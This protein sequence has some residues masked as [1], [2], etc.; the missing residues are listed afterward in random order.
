MHHIASDGWSLG[1]LTSEFASLYNAA[2]RGEPGDL[3][4]LPVQYADYASWQRRWLQ[5]E[6]LQGQL[7]YW[8]RQL[9]GV[10]TVHSLPLDRPRSAMQSFRG[11]TLKRALD[12]DLAVRITA[13]CRQQD[14]TLFMLL[15]TAFA[16][17]L[18]RYSDERDIVVGTPIAGRTH[19]DV[20]PLIG[21]FVNSLALRTRVEP[22]HA[23]I[24]QLRRNR[25]TILDAYT[26][27]HVPFEMLVE[28]LR[29]ARSLNHSPIFQV[30]FALQNNDGIRLALDGIELQSEPRANE[31]AKFDLSLFVSEHPGGLALKWEYCIALFDAATIER[32]AT[33]F[34]VLLRAV[35]DAPETSMA[36]LPL[37]DADARQRML[38]LAHG[39]QVDVAEPIAQRAFERQAARTPQAVA[40]SM[41]DRTLSYGELE[42]AANRLAHKLQAIGAQR[43]DLVAIRA[44]R[45]PELI[46]AILAVWKSGAAVLPIDPAYPP[47]RQRFMLE[48]A[49]VRV[50]LTDRASHAAAVDDF[51]VDTVIHLDDSSLRSELETLTAT[52]P[53]AINAAND[54]AYCLYTSGTT[55]QPKGVAMPH[56]A[57]ANLLV[58]QAV[59]LPRMRE[60]LKTLQFTSIGFDVALQEILTTLSTGGELRLIDESERAD[61]RLLAR[62]LRDDGIERAFM[63]FAVL[64]ALAAEVCRDPTGTPSL[65]LLVTAGEALR[66]TAELRQWLT[67]MPDCQL[68]NHYGPTE[69]HVVTAHS[70]ELDYRSWDDLPPIGRPLPNCNVYLLDH[71]L[72][73]VPVGVVGEIYVGGPCNALGYLHRPDLD[74]ERFVVSPFKQD[75]GQHL[76]RTGDLARSLADGSIRHVGRRDDQIKIRGYRV[77]LVEI[78]ARLGECDGVAECAVVARRH[79]QRGVYVVAYVVSDGS[80]ER[81]AAPEAYRRALRS[82]LPEYMV[83]SS[84]LM[85]DA[86]PLT[87]NGKVDRAALPDVEVDDR[88]S[89]VEPSGETERAVA[90]VWCEVLGRTSIGRHDN[91][92]DVGGHSLLA[93]SLA[94]HLNRALG[95]EISL[96]ELFERQT[97][98]EQAELVDTRRWLIDSGSS[99]SATQN[100]MDVIEL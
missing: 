69:T 30:L 61:L 17:L 74:A 19:A 73:P 91:F 62:R 14:V 16:V 64:Q 72:Q 13:L 51:R 5:G 66:M 98:A 58:A 2:R 70:S 83:P 53:A 37:L 25:E 94:S 65:R 78:E 45:S 26:H 90:A 97:I 95:V 42:R 9:H 15:Q 24:D 49:E 39:E 11:Q 100:D 57:L 55:G 23:F 54:L 81:D 67:A 40:L 10:P 59:D 48:Q 80:M 86:M 71:G 60:P 3:A 87:R 96:R 52:P 46:I 1:I 92:F 29:P 4:A 75:G 99:I 21:F 68:V 35:V 41:T 32:M 79:P 36:S 20:E 82:V 56:R 6:V 88:A 44:Q 89:F 7:D 63:P 50:L 34:E 38:Q 22:E 76:Y 33:A 77:E 85:L 31:T 12:R 47:A 27:Q 93:T 84:F 28:E 8:R 43:N 18:S